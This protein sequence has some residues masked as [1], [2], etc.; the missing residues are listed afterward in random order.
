MTGGSD[1]SVTEAMVDLTRE[2]TLAIAALKRLAKRWPKTLW[3]F[4]GSGGLEIMRTNE[5][6]N[7]AH[8]GHGGEAYDPAY[9]VGH[10]DIEADGG[11]W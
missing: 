9:I 3:L 8:T 6:G 1:A 4:A 10:A 7:H 5:H 11:D 2:E